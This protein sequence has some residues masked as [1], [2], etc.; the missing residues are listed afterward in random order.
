MYVY[1]YMCIYICIYIYMYIYLYVYV[2]VCNVY[3]KEAMCALTEKKAKQIAYY[4]CQ[5]YTIQKE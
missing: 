3:K 1:I 2:Y 4:R 5:Q